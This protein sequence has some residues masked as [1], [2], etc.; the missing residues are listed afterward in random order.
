[1]V[2]IRRP[3]LIRRRE[4]ELVPSPAQNSQRPSHKK[5]GDDVM[6][7]SSINLYIGPTSIWG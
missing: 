1:M 3:P 4:R 2:V 7:M 6:M 5:Q